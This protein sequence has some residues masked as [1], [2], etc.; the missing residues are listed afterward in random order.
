MP[1][2]TPLT[3]RRH[4]G[5]YIVWEPQNGLV[6]R[7]EVI[8]ASGA[9]ECE[10]GLV[11]GQVG[12]A[13]TAVAAAQGVNTG[14]YTFGAIA[15]AAP[16]VAGV[17][18]LRMQDATHY[19]VEDPDGEQI[20]HGVFGT[21]FAAG[22]LSFTATAGATPAVAGDSSTLTVGVGSLK[23]VAYD[24]TA[25]NGAERAAAIL[26]DFRDATAADRK[27]TAN[28]RGP[29]RINAAELVWGAGVTTTQHRTDA[30]AALA[31]LPGGGI[32][33]S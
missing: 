22:G 14:N 13:L 7:D 5:G 26:W 16:A 24:P 1:T 21:A 6:T 33:A 18:I 9:G 27:A 29:M 32:Q 28:I 12:H 3:E 15:V 30:L 17:Y 20:G 4:A 25:N 11:L 2:V 8:I 31:G 19:V 23:Y 10:A